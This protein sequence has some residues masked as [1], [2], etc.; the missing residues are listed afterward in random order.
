MRCALV[1]IED[2]T[3]LFKLS[4]VA[5]IYWNLSKSTLCKAGVPN[6]MPTNTMAPAE[7]FMCDRRCA[8][9]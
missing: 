5:Y 1:K 2:I 6:P 9:R 4:T 7:R 8:T 3:L